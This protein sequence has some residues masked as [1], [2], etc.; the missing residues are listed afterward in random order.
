VE[1]PSPRSTGGG[2]GQPRS[3]PVLRARAGHTQLG[4]D[5]A[6]SN[7]DHTAQ[8]PFPSVVVVDADG[9]VRFVDVKVDSTER[10]EVAT[11]L[12]AVDALTVS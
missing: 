1:D 7:A 6:D 4:F 2:G 10:T 9:V 8:I 5:V 12:S 3:C 11:V